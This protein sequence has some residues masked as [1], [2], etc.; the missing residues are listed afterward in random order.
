MTCN[1]P[2]RVTHPLS[3][4]VLMPPCVIGVD[5]G[6]GGIRA[7][8]FDLRGVALAFAD[9]PYATHFPRPGRAEQT[10]SD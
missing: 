10:P 3:S 1:K 9:V 8:V 6:T 4:S 7:G 2:A 5:G